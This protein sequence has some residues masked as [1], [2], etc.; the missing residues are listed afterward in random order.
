MIDVEQI[1]K[2]FGRK[3]ALSGFTLHVGAGELFGLVWPEWRRQDHADENPFPTLLPIDSGTAQIGG[4][5]V[6]TQGREV[7]R[8]IGYLPDQPGCYQDMSVREFSGVSLQTLSNSPG[9]ATELLWTGPWNGPG[10]MIVAAIPSSNSR[11]A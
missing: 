3:L 9:A 2:E 7:K 6:T 8:L 4:L 11:L 1:R 5:D 10:S